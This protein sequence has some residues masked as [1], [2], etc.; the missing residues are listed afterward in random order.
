[1][2]IVFIT[3]V[4]LSGNE[5]SKWISERLD[6][7]SGWQRFK[8]KGNTIFRRKEL[9]GYDLF[10]LE[11]SREVTISPN[12]V[13]EVL[14]DVNNYGRVLG[15]NKYLEAEEVKVDSTEITGYQ[16]ARIPLI[17]NRHYLFSFDMDNY[18]DSLLKHEKKLI[19][20]LLEPEEE[21]TDFIEKKNKDNHNPL[22][23]KNGSGIWKI[24]KLS[25]GKYLNSYR[26]YLD[27]AG[28][29][30]SWLV[31]TFNVKNLEQLFNRVLQAASERS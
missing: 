19:W 7:E 20:L 9:A 30:P 29:M 22:Y 8:E 1:M 26:L 6:E 5:N 18:R 3:G 21:F 24:E 14:L 25:S 27:P 17:P 11:I 13:F 15:E 23:I 12:A 4:I 2:I 10:A 31:N 28:W 16:Y